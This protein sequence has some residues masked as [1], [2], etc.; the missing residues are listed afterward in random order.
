MSFVL[1]NSKIAP[2]KQLSIPRLELRATVNSVLLT[3]LVFQEHSLQIDSVAHQT[4]SVTVLQWLH[5]ADKKQS[6]FVANDSDRVS[7][8]FWL[9]YRPNDGPLSLRL[10]N[11]ASDGFATVAVI[12]N[13]SMTQKPI[14]NWRNVSTFS[15]CVQVIAFCLRFK[16]RSQCEV[17]LL[18]G[19]E[20]AEAKILNLNQQETFLKK[21]GDLT[22]F[23]P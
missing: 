22:K 9:K 23:S 18:S 7:G 4:E 17:L 8:P 15:N 16:C 13:T 21:G 3:A 19:F 14:V 10:T 12:A 2:N 5:S 6:I 20:Q 11:V 1:G